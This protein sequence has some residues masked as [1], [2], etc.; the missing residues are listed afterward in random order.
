MIRYLEES[1]GAATPIG[2]GDKDTK[3]QGHEEGSPTKLQPPD[4]RSGP[5]V[6]TLKPQPSP[7]ERTSGPDRTTG[8][9][10]PEPKLAEV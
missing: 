9:T 7:S 6:W 1:H 4:N 10:A 8:V 2:Q 3:R 5:D